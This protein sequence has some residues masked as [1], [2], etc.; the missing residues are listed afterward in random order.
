MTNSIITFL[1]DVVSKGKIRLALNSTIEFLRDIAQSDTINANDFNILFLLSSQLTDVEKKMSIEVIKEDEYKLQKTKIVG[2]FLDWISTNEN[3]FNQTN[4]NNYTIVFIEDIEIRINLFDFYNSNQLE[5]EKFFPNKNIKDEIY[6]MKIIIKALYFNIIK[7]HQGKLDINN[8]NEFYSLLIDIVIE[9]IKNISVSHLTNTDKLVN[10]I[11]KLLF[12][13]NYGDID[14][15]DILIEQKL[16]NK[17]NDQVVL[18][19]NTFFIIVV[20]SKHDFIYQYNNLYTKNPTELASSTFHF[21]WSVYTKLIKLKGAFYELK[22]ENN[23]FN[24][25]FHL[26]KKTNIEIYDFSGQDLSCMNLNFNDLQNCKFNNCKFDKSSLSYCNLTNTSFIG[27]TLSCSDFSNSNLTNTNF[28]DADL[29]EA[30]FKWTK[31]ENSKFHNTIL[32]ST[33]MENVDL[34]KW[35]KFNS[36]IKN[37]I[38]NKQ[39]IISNDDIQSLDSKTQR[40][41]KEQAKVVSITKIE[42]REQNIY[43]ELK[44]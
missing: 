11:F 24:K 21:I 42:I 27:S 22:F 31:I 12:N 13:I 17:K 43:K 18:L 5:I 41:F 23:V 35:N 38:T 3:T 20:F 6:L 2:A 26:I 4:R 19:N 9:C 25:I 8:R 10:T 34:T 37:I 36:D 32:F 40:R 16:L 44:V 1:Q 33:Y 14:Q 30:K 15:I 39:T 28:T 29:T 7:I